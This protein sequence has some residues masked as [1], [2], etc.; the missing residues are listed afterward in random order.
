MLKAKNH[1]DPICQDDGTGSEFH[2]FMEAQD[3]SELDVVGERENHDNHEIIQNL[4]VTSCKSHGGICGDCNCRDSRVAVEWMG[5]S[6][7]AIGTTKALQRRKRKYRGVY[8]TEAATPLRL[9]HQ[10]INKDQQ[11]HGHLNRKW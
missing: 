8:E 6:S 7:M 9:E 1:M 4:Y 3:V 10:K 2:Q 11:L 5:E